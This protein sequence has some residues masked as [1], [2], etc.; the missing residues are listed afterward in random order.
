MRA[1][2]VSLYRAAVPLV[3][4]GLVWSG[5]LF[6][7]DDR[8]LAKANK[9]A[10]ELDDQI[11]GN[12]AVVSI[13]ANRNWR[14][15]AHGRVYYYTA[16]DVPRQTIMGVSTFET[17]SHPFRLLSHTYVA[18]ATLVKGTWKADQGWTQRFL[19]A[20][21]SV[22]DSFTKRAVPLATP[23][24]FRDAVKEPDLMTFTELRRH[25]ADL[26]TSGLN[27]AESKVALQERVAFPLVTVVMT[28]LGIPFGVT[29]GRR[30]ALYGVG[31]AVILGSAYW[32]LNTFF[33]A[34]GQ[35]S[36]LPATLAAWAA[37]ILF[38]AAALY[39]T[40]TVRT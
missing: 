29:T 20:E 11:R 34:V 5:G 6:M 7:L 37:N 3:L 15:D 31:L 2:G 40:L 18:R 1:C 8:V 19:S 16:L 27:I 9:R 22:R 10:A 24:F 13:V 32:L 35:A 39:F 23:D 17:A 28:V 26:R 12:P 30:G 36:L 33:L 21:A 4:L 25:I 38:L 14:T